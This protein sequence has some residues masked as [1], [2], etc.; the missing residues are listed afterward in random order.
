MITINL[1]GETIAYINK[2][3]VYEDGTKVD[4]EPNRVHKAVGINTTD[5]TLKPY[6]LTQSITDTVLSLTLR[7]EKLERELHDKDETI[8]IT[9]IDTLNKAVAQCKK[10][11]NDSIRRRQY[12]YDGK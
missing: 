10:E 2:E 9:A 6:E 7:V 8:R 3:W 11:L 1:N 4:L 12:T 5:T